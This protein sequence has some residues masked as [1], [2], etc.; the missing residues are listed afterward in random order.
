MVPR[1]L[2]GGAEVDLSTTVLGERLAIPL[3]GAPTGLTGLVHH[4]GEVAVA[5]A[6]Q[7]AGG[8]YVLSSAA[9][10]GIDGSRGCAGPRWFQI[11]VS[12]DRGVSRSLIERARA[13]ATPRWW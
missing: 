2:A 1:V 7:A 10:R 4:E 11:Y 6:V 12:L 3:L 9:S 5:R 8:L 13:G